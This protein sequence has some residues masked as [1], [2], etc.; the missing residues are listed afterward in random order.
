MVDDGI[1]RV[2]STWRFGFPQLGADFPMRVRQMKQSMLFP[3]L[4]FLAL[5]GAPAQLIVSGK[6]AVADGGQLPDRVVI[7]RDCGGAW[8]NV[9]YADRK[10]QF[11]FRWSETAGITG[12]DAS[13]SGGFGGPRGFPGNGIGQDSADQARGPGGGGPSMTGCELRAAAAGY[14]SEVITLNSN[15]TFLDSYDAGTILLHRTGDTAA[16]AVSATSLKAP[17]DARRAFDKG[18]EAVGKAKNSDAEKDFEKAVSL[19]PLYAE[20]WLDLGKLR[21]QRKADDSAGEA[22]RKALEADGNLAEPQVYLGMLAVE[23]KQ[24]PDAVKYLDGALKLDP[25]HFPDAW[26]N[27]AVAEYNLKDYSNAERSVR[28]ALKSDPQ[29]KNS[30]AEYLL[31]LILAAQK[32]YSGA[33]EQLR[34]YLKLAPDADDAEKVRTQLTEIE[35]LESASHH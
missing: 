15:R 10:G 17:S 25:V 29:H 4:F 27:H 35:K 1:V 28:E 19:Y 26:F 31:G 8:R 30:R 9:A 22:F 34:V 5:P 21:L 23:N 18:L 33:A 3:V 6:V 14:R 13:Q 32:D 16:P 7:E 20:A 11:N 12:G 2:E 24:W